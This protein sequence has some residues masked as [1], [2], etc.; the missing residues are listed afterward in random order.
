MWRRGR[1]GHVAVQFR[2]GWDSRMLMGRG[3][4]RTWRGES[5]GIEEGWSGKSGLD[6]CD[7]SGLFRI[8]W[9][10]VVRKRLG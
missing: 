9:T 6:W 10:W 7:K 1:V 3:E 8:G 2:P 4:E 5:V